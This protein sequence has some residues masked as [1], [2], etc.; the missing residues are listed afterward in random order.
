MAETIFAK[1]G[2]GYDRAQVDAFLVEMNRSFA[3]KETLLQ[4]KIKQLTASLADTQRMLEQCKREQADAE[5][6]YTAELQEKERSFTALQAEIGQRMLAADARAEEIVSAAKA[7]ADDQ[8]ARARTEADTC[9][10]EA[11]KRAAAEADRIVTETKQRCSRIGEAAAEFSARIHAVSD[12]LRKTEAIADE[13][14]ESFRRKA[15]RGE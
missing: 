5:A 12:E 7:K 4:D 2:R 3:E 11:R 1:A 9:L 10:T 14:L 6:K 13:T 8:L 15:F